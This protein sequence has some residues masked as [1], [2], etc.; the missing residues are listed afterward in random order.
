MS[1]LEWTVVAAVA[2]LTALGV[3][4][5]LVGRIARWRREAR[6]KPILA[7]FRVQELPLG[8]KPDAVEPQL[9]GS[10]EVPGVVGRRRPTLLREAE[11]GPPA[12]PDAASKGA[13]TGVGIDVKTARGLEPPPSLAPAP[14][15][16]G[17]GAGLR[18]VRAEELSLDEQ[19]ALGSL[20]DEEATLEDQ[21]RHLRKEQARLAQ[22]S[23]AGGDV[24]SKALAVHGV[25]EVEELPVDV[26]RTIG[27]QQVAIKKFS[28]ELDAMERSVRRKS[29]SLAELRRVLSRSTRTGW[30][31][32]LEA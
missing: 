28:E 31:R 2:G 9:V 26:R 20:S 13:S 27:K 30:G 32:K 7:P 1:G 5:L 22:L 8:E 29:E 11:A 18:S 12:R 21:M 24:L 10:E 4:T 16:P 23:L 3:L 6:R 15:L 14:A 19:R 17:G 25:P